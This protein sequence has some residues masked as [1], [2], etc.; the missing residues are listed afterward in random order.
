MQT[1][2]A[3]YDLIAG[4]GFLDKYQASDLYGKAFRE[5]INYW[6]ANPNDQAV[7]PYHLEI[8]KSYAILSGNHE[9]NLDL[10]A[11]K[12]RILTF[13]LEDGMGL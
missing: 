13:S 12:Q 3:A 8:Y 2:K 10:K 5:F 6:S 4:I 7:K 1:P 9:D 11:A